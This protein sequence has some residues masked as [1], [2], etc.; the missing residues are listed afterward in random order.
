MLAHITAPKIP[1]QERKKTW[2]SP[3]TQIT[4]INLATGPWRLL[5]VVGIVD[6]GLVG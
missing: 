5:V 3:G 6:S 1:I 2:K 4:C